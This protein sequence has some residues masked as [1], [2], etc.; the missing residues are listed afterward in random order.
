MLEIFWTRKRCRICYCPSKTFATIV[1]LLFKLL[2]FPP[3]SLT[4]WSSFPI[5]CFVLAHP[6][7]F[8]FQTQGKSCMCVCVRVCVRACARACAPQLWYPQQQHINRWLGLSADCPKDSPSDQAPSGFPFFPPPRLVVWWPHLSLT[9]SMR[10]P[11]C[12]RIQMAPALKRPASGSPWCILLLF[13][14][15]ISEVMI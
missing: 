2:L 9:S 5:P 3:L 13:Q 12:H 8:S 1:F 15:S 6:S 11:H 14:W 10:S 7:F 4:D